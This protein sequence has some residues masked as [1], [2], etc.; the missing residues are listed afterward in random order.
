M[1][2]QWMDICYIEE[3]FQLGKCFL[4]CKLYFFFCSYRPNMHL[5]KAVTLCKHRIRHSMC[6][7]YMKIRNFYSRQ[8]SPR[9]I[10]NEIRSQTN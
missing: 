3:G 7:N 5:S 10:R 9:R 6:G 8:F 4:W 1:Y 2:S